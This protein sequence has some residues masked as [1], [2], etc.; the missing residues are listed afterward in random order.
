MWV[1]AGKKKTVTVKW[2]VFSVNTISFS[3]HSHVYFLSSPVF[4]PVVVY[5]DWS[6]MRMMWHS[7]KTWLWP[8]VK[9]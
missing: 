1:K 6:L 9:H 4:R 3:C 5:S 2:G 7:D 8:P